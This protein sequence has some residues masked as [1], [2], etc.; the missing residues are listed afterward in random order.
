MIPFL[1]SFGTSSSFEAVVVEDAS[2]KVSSKDFRNMKGEVHRIQRYL[3]LNHIM[4]M[5][6][7]KHWGMFIVG[8]SGIPLN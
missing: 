4:G 2:V 5:V 1:F 6:A 8:P 3:V 7:D